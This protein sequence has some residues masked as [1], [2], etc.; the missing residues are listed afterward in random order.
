MT[1]AGQDPN[2]HVPKE[3]SPSTRR[4]HLYAR[5]NS[6]N[7]FPNLMLLPVIPN[8]T[9]HISMLYQCRCCICQT[10]YP[11]LLSSMIMLFS[12]NSG[13]CFYQSRNVMIQIDSTMAAKMKNFAIRSSIE[14]GPCRRRCARLVNRPVRLT[15]W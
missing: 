15:A 3:R 2:G 14:S 12:C 10:L 6:C 8:P 4:L 9:P 13:R 5:C 7:L 1:N 11:K